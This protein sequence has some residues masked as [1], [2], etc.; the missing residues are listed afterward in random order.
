MIYDMNFGGEPMM[1]GDA[2][3]A[4]D[5]V[6]TEL[7]LGR[8]ASSMDM[9]RESRPKP[10]RPASIGRPDTAKR[11]RERASISKHTDTHIDRC[12]ARRIASI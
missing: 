3:P 1:G 6:R 5:D 8:S 10:T 7:R 9:A 12:L 4:D 2:V 11:N